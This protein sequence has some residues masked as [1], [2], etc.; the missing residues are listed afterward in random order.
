MM[1]VVLAEARE[2]EQLLRGQRPARVAGH[3]TLL[4]MEIQLQ[5]LALEG[6]CFHVAL[7]MEDVKVRFD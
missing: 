5:Q 3:S 7:P 4:A 6:R 1:A 2:A